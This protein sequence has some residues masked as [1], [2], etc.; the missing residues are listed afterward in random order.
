MSKP[1]RKHTFGLIFGSLPRQ[2]A[3]GRLY[4]GLAF[5]LALGVA[6]GLMPSSYF[7]LLALP[8]ALLVAYGF[9]RL[10]LE[11]RLVASAR[12]SERQSEPPK[13]KTP[14][15][16]ATRRISQLLS[17]ASLLNIPVARALPR[18]ARLS[19]QQRQALVQIEDTQPQA[20]S[21]GYASLSESVTTLPLGLVVPK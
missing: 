9:S 7:L 20:A 8:A 1:E 17:P 21:P 11:P 15:R 3:R 10:F 18:G 12:P 19:A 16:T 14:A 13:P 4:L 6:V 2:L 5:S